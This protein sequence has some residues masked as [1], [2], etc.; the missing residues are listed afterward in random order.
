MMG[1]VSGLG[2]ALKA[3]AGQL[4]Q[5]G[6]GG[7][8]GGA[9]DMPEG[10]PD[11]N[12]HAAKKDFL[13]RGGEQLPPGGL[14]HAIER[15]RSPYVIPM[16]WKIPAVLQTGINSEGPGGITGVVSQDV[17][18]GATGR[19]LLIPKGA[20]LV[21]TYSSKVTQ[22]Q[23]RVQVAWVRINYPDGSTLDLGSM[24]GT[25]QEGVTGFSHTV[26]THFMERFGAALLASMFTVAFEV[27]A[28]KT[29][30][31]I[32]NSVHRGVGE[33]LT[34]F[35]INEAGRIGQQPPTLKI[36]VGYKFE[37]FVTRAVTFAKPYDDGID[38]SMRR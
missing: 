20:M 5:G 23:R 31:G 11:P 10:M 1:G 34:Q 28:P 8:G 14:E 35:G 25:D 9:A 17:F 36:P 30:L 18:D 32:E 24:P 15:P 6:G 27:T 21:G 4:G 3:A 19:H 29:G 7:V 2:E 26:D 38:R 12:A 22:G 33:S 13:Q 37:V 16:G